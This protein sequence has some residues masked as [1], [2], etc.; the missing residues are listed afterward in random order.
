[1]CAGAEH[2]AAHAF[3][4]GACVQVQSD[5]GTVAKKA[6]N[7]ASDLSDLPNP[8]KG[9]PGSTDPQTLAKDA[10]SAVCLICDGF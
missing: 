1:M 7:V 8:F 5:V 4:S 9:G 10:K 3:E 6:K 2:N